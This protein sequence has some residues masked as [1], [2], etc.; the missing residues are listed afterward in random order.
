MKESV[1]IT[2]KGD[3]AYTVSGAMERE[4]DTLI[5]RYAEPLSLG[6]GA[7]ETELTL[8]ADSALLRRSGAVRCH[9]RFQPG[10]VHTSVYET[11]L[12]SFPAELET[13]SLRSRLGKRGGV[14]ELRYRLRLGGAA[15][16]HRLRI[17]IQVEE[18]EK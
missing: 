14:A 18:A 3:A 7:V 6:M 8:S 2:L 15:E 5:L 4:G 11:A 12:G 1:T 10:A 16:E 9:F 13:H 17:Q